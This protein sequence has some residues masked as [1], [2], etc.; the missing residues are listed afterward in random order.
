M[1]SESSAFLAAA[2]ATSSCE[3]VVCAAAPKAA[4][5][6][7]AAFRAEELNASAW[8]EAS[9]ARSTLARERDAVTERQQHH[10]HPLVEMDLRVQRLYRA[11]VRPV[12]R[13]RRR[14]AAQRVVEHQET[15][16]AQQ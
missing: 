7:A 12:G 6:S 8:P 3:S 10:V 9:P 2:E 16:G 13:V 14:A 5:S 15:A 11:G 1:P 4:L